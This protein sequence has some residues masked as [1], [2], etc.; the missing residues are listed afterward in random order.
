MGHRHCLRET[1]MDAR[2]EVRYGQCVERV[3][4]MAGIPAAAC[5]VRVVSRRVVGSWVDV[6]ELA[7]ESTVHG[8]LVG[9]SPR[10]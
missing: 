2:G 1:E 7:G 4:G 10:E 9:N 8:G 5:M 6:S 3:F